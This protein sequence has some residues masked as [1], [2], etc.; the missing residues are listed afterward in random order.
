MLVEMGEYEDALLTTQK[1]KANA[2]KY[3]RRFM[4]NSGKCVR[5]DRVK[6]P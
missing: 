5:C 3:S 2:K 6:G 1:T 4:R